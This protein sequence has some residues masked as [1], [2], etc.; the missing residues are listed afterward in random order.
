LEYPFWGTSAAQIIIRRR[1]VVKIKKKIT[2]LQTL[3]VE[4]KILKDHLL[5]HFFYLIY[6]A[7]KKILLFKFVHRFLIPTEVLL[8]D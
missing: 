4:K 2:P 5:L 3:G 8:A 1:S 6:F 7:K